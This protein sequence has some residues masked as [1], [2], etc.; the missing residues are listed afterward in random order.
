MTRRFEWLN[1]PT[2]GVDVKQR[3]RETINEHI[4]RTL[5]FPDLDELQGSLSDIAPRELA[6]GLSALVTAGFITPDGSGWFRLASK[7]DVK[8][9]EPEP[10]LK[11][12]PE[13]KAIKRTT[14]PA[15]ARKAKPADERT[16]GVPIY[17]V[18]GVMSIIGIGA[19]VISVYY[20]TIWLLEFL[21]AVFALLLSSIMIGFSIASFETVI[22]FMSGEVTRSRWVK[23]SIATGFILLWIVVS[24]FSIMSTVAGQYNKHVSNLRDQA[25]AGISTGRAQW[26]ILQEQ[27]GELQKRLS[28]YQKQVTTLTNIMDGMGSVEARKNNAGVWAENQWQLQKANEQMSRIAS[29]LDKVREQERAQIE[30]SRKSGVLLSLA[31]DLK[32]VP[33]FYGWMSTIVKV[34]RDKVQ[35]WLALFPA[36]FC[37]VMG[38]IG[39]AMGLFLRRKKR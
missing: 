22:L 3:V 16:Y 7:D 19:A 18:Q 24:F 26:G 30:E 6:R 38:P 4:R 25:K 35:F 34:D 1:I 9:P 11:E 32:Q 2:G 27:K 33:D 37:D 23:V 36:V 31:G 20:T 21:P 28:D 14:K 15:P 17:I 12:E 29:D 13:R 8:A 10:P 39:I 5:H